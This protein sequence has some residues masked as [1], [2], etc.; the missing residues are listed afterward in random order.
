MRAQD[1]RQVR[2]KWNLQAYVI[3]NKTLYKVLTKVRATDRAVLWNFEKQQRE[4]HSYAAVAQHGEKAYSLYD[5]GKMLD[6]SPYTLKG[7]IKEFP[8]PYV[9][10][11]FTQGKPHGKRWDADQVMQIREVIANTH[12]GAPRKDG[13]IRPRATPSRQELRAMLNQEAVFYVQ[14][15]TGKFVPSWKAH[16]F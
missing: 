11:S 1:R 4:V 3:L 15:Q 7:H 8:A 5:I 13:E 16:Q 14:T 2:H 9:I 6:R 12:Y 10:Y